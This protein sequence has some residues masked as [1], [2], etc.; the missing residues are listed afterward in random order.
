MNIQHAFKTIPMQPDTIHSECHHTTFSTMEW[1]G[2]QIFVKYMKVYI[3]WSRH[4]FSILKY[5]QRIFVT[6]TKSYG[7]GNVNPLLF[8]GPLQPWQKLFYHKG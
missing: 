7:G 8:N 2:E 4:L 6:T 1:R 5:S 3:S